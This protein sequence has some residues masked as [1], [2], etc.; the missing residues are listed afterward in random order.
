MY[1]ASFDSTSTVVP[2]FYRNR[3]AEGVP[4]Q[5]SRAFQDFLVTVG[6]GMN[7]FLSNHFA[8]RPEANLMVVTDWSDSRRVGVFGVQLVYHIDPHPIV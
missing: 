1:R 5:G 6:G 8:L 2:A 7:V 4:G 3:M